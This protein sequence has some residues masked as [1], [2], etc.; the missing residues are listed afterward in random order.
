MN[1]NQSPQ[2][3]SLNRLTTHKRCL[4]RLIADGEEALTKLCANSATDGD[5]KK[6]TLLLEVGKYAVLH[7]IDP[8]GTVIALNKAQ[9]SLN[10][11]AKSNTTTEW[12]LVRS[13]VRLCTQIGSF[14]TERELKIVAKAAQKIEAEWTID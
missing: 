10:H 14:L 9:E 13:A 6:L 1:R 12:D 8:A 2:L 3:A 11:Y 4:Q 7:C 5:I